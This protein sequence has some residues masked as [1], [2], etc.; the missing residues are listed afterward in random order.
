MYLHKIV[1]CVKNTPWWDRMLPWCPRRR[2]GALEGGWLG[3][4]VLVGSCSGAPLT[5]FWASAMLILSPLFRNFFSFWFCNKLHLGYLRLGND[6]RA[7]IL[8]LPIWLRPHII[9][10]CVYHIICN[11][12]SV[13]T[14]NCMPP[15]QNACFVGQEWTLFFV[16]VYKAKPHKRSRKCCDVCLD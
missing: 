3:P 16:S 4:R 12:C 7:W 6:Q 14:C 13:E 2:P 15:L 1:T 10:M 5:G 9:C 8:S 11:M